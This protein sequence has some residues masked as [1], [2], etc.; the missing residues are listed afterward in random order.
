[1]R[2]T[3]GDFYTVLTRCDLGVEYTIAPPS[4]GAGCTSRSIGRDTDERICLACG[5]P[6]CVRDT[7]GMGAVNNMS[8][9]LAVIGKSTPLAVIG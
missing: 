2:T 8:R 5:C 7:N 1:M 9:R 6:F 3:F 4:R